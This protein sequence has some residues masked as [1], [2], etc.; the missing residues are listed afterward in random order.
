M[1]KLN[2][3]FTFKKQEDPMALYRDKVFAFRINCA[4]M[5]YNK[6]GAIISAEIPKR[7]PE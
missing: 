5:K 6:T 4:I 1:Q 2:K 7:S 3:D